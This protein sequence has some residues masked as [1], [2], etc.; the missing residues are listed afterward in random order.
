MSAELLNISPLP[1]ATVVEFA[2]PDDL[3]SSEFDRLNE[4][5]A[6]IFVDRRPARWVLDLGPTRY[7]GSAML[8]LMV[9]IRHRVKSVNGKLALCGMSP[10]LHAIFK[11]CCLEKLFTI[12]RTREDALK[13]LR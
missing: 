10:A 2:L 13:L 7:M 5:I 11:A 12:A 9:N 6:E 8:G 1:T 3:D 4:R